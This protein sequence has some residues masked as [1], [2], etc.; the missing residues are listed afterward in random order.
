[1]QTETYKDA[2]VGI[3]MAFIHGH[4]PDVKLDQ[5]QTDI[6]QEKRL[7]AVDVN[8]S[9]RILRSSYIQ[10]LHWEYFGSPVQ[11]NPLRSG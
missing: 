6:I 8:P 10:N 3:K 11:M 4:H 2:V 5:T 9:G 7:T 1:V